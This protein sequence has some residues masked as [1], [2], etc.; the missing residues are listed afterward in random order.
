[1]QPLERDVETLRKIPLFAG[2]PTAR[3]KL[4]AYTA[5]VVEFAPGER[6][7]G[8]GDPADAVYIVTEGEAEVLLQD[9]DGHEIMVTTMGRNSLFGET[10]VISKGRR[11][12]TVR[13]R[14]RVVTFKISADVFLDLV[15]QSPEISMQVMTVLAQRLERSSALLQQHQSHS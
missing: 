7:V 9:A 12:A 14:D 1:M 6:I 10:A 11:T 2:L 4:I 3:L 15:R 5:E 8:Q 13:A